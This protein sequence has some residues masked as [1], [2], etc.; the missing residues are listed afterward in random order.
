M[1][2]HSTSLIREHLT[3]ILDDISEF[4]IIINKIITHIIDE[5][6]REEDLSKVHDQSPLNPGGLETDDSLEG[7]IYTWYLP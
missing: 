5:E 7:H 6:M 1:L 2:R 4:I 3:F